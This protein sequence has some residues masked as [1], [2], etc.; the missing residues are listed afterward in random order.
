MRL[1]KA[2][3]KDAIKLIAREILYD[4]IEN[5]EKAKGEYYSFI[6][7]YIFEFDNNDE[8]T[9]LKLKRIITSINKNLKERNENI[10]I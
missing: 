10:I 1:L 2:Q 7:K 8:A 6:K 9:N 4:A 5:L 3:C